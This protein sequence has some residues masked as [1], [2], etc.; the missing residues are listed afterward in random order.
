MV[1]KIG[2]IMTDKIT[3]NPVITAIQQALAEDTA[4]DPAEEKKITELLNK[5][6]PEERSAALQFLNEKCGGEKNESVCSLF[7]NYSATKRE[8]DRKVAMASGLLGE[9]QKWREGRG[10][11]SDFPK[12]DLSGVAPIA[13]LMED[14]YGTGGV[15]GLGPRGAGSRP[16][17][18]GPGIGGIGLYGRSR[19]AGRTTGNIDLGGHGK[20]MERVIGRD[21]STLRGGLSKDVIGRIIRRNWAQIKYVYEKALGRNRNLEGKVVFKFAINPEGKVTDLKLESDTIK[22]P[23]M[24]NEV[25]EVFEQIRFPKPEGGGFVD[26]TYPLDFKLAK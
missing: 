5:A 23:Q 11:V 14:P 10:V 17:D 16:T 19:D 6:T 25:K 26:V 3:N 2:D 8:A 7:K 9:L 21:A 22:D 12:A 24:L 1:G 18:S 13:P 4:I 15:G 20:G